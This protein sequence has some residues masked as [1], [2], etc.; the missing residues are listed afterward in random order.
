[1]KIVLLSFWLPEYCI[2]LANAL[3]KKVE[4]YLL[5][6]DKHIQYYETYI[7][8]TV[9]KVPY[10]LPRMRSLLPNMLMLGKLF[11]QLGVLSPSLVHMQAG[12]PWFNL[13]MPYVH[14]KYPFVTT[15]HD[16][17]THP[18]DR[19]SKKF[20]FRD[21][22]IRHSDRFI[23]HGNQLKQAFTMK[24]KIP[25]YRVD[26]IHHG[27]YS[28][29]S[30]YARE[31]IEGQDPCVLFFGRIFD[32]KGLEYLIKAEPLISRAVPGLKIIIAGRGDHFDKYDK[33]IVNR[34]KFIILNKYI[35]NRKTAELFQKARVVALPYTE[36]S[37]SGIIP[38]A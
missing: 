10:N 23:V 28:I 15:V 7:S 27:V 31:R 21:L 25:G 13:I 4:L 38:L 22:T 37:Q 8:S 6:P 26:S 9:R 36:A 20:F 2:Q 19:D 34:D 17:D 32:Y 1:M 3:S 35:D 29:Y 16:I 18:G 14:K 24:Y 11:R 5:L 30:S 33:M 12:Y